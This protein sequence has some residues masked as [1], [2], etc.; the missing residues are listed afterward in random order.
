MQKLNLRLLEHSKPEDPNVLLC[1]DFGTALS[2]AAASRGRT[3]Y[4]PLLLPLGQIAKDPSAANHY[5]AESSLFVAREGTLHFGH[6]AFD[7]WSR[8]REY[9]IARLDSMKRWL[10][11]GPI[12]DLATLPVESNFLP[13][14]TVLSKGEALTLILAYV[15]DL[16]GRGLKEAGHSRYV[17]RRFTRPAW[18][19]ERGNWCDR[20][21][22]RMLASAQIVADT[23][24]GKWLDSIP[25]NEAQEIIRRAAHEETRIG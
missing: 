7:K 15:T 2:K 22:A 21:M 3:G 19:E 25:L 11:S 14:G 23:F 6:D 17:R 24:S 4:R 12:A 8:Q 10:S 16:A 18:D 9:S 1:I 5:L 20:E 13:N